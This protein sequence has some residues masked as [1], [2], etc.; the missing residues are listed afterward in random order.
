MQT[1]PEGTAPTL[2]RIHGRLWPCAVRSVQ[3]YNKT[4]ISRAYN[5][6]SVAK[7]TREQCRVSGNPEQA[8][9]LPQSVPLNKEQA[10]RASLSPCDSAF[11]RFPSLPATQV[12]KATDHPERHRTMRYE[13]PHRNGIQEAPGP[14]TSPS[15][16]HLTGNRSFW[17]FEGQRSSAL[18]GAH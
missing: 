13:E 2:I 11:S 7:G 4:G 6:F 10:Y 16:R 5:F 9:A 15:P 17:A 8:G 1:R 12:L 14:G 3:E 18:A